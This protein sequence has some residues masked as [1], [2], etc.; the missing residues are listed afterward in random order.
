MGLG[1]LP[2]AAWCPPIV[3][4]NVANGTSGGAD[5]TVSGSITDLA[6]NAGA[7]LQKLGAGKLVLSAANYYVGPTVISAGFRFGLLGHS[8]IYRHPCSRRF[9]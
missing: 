5:L 6:G 1:L 4:F 3:S 9:H 8:G 2:I 7:T